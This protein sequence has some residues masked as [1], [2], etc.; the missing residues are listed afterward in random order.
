ME[1]ET[2]GGMKV[3]VLSSD[4]RGMKQGF[5]KVGEPVRLE[6]DSQGRLSQKTIEAL[7][8]KPDKV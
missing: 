1:K 3:V 4:G 5:L 6:W 2:K 7:S 8:L